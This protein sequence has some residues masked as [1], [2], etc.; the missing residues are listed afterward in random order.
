[1]Y[2]QYTCT[3]EQTNI[4]KHH[5]SELVA[6]REKKTAYKTKANNHDIYEITTF[7]YTGS[8]HLQICTKHVC[9]II[10]RPKYGLPS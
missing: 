10:N 8:Q 1:M 4:V 2:I 7:K 6:K 5:N 9:M 3:I